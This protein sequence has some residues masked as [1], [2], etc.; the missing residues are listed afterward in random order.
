MERY[1]V[2]DPVTY[3]LLAVAKKEDGQ[4]LVES[5]PGGVETI[6][7]AVI[8]VPSNRPKEQ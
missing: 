8:H 2:C 7:G 3:S 5:E 1:I 6:F 4:Y